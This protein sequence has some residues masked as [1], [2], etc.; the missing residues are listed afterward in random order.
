MNRSRHHRAHL[1]HRR[2]R[3]KWLA[4]VAL[5]C[6]LSVHNL[7]SFAA[8]GDPTDKAQCLSMLHSAISARCQEMFTDAKQKTACLQQVESHVEQTCQQFFGQGKDFCATCTSSCT[9]TFDSG[10][11]RRK[12]CLAMCLT[13]RG[14]Q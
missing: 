6:L 11:K 8:A 12:E 9:Q 10:D 1:T 13:Q 7:A 14:C 5:G 2:L 4:A 3:L